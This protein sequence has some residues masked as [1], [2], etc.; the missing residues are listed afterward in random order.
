MGDGK[1]FDNLNPAKTRGCV[2]L[3]DAYAAVFTMSFFHCFP[4]SIHRR[5]KLIE[6]YNKAN[7][8]FEILGLVTLCSTVF[9]KAGLNF[10]K[11]RTS[12]VQRMHTS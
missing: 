8:I 1:Q 5:I 12:F 11:A 4:I 9:T 2:P 10:T 6:A 3:L 7:E